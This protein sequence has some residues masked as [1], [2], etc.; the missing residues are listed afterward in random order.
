MI[1]LPENEIV[2]LESKHRFL[3]PKAHSGLP[4]SFLSEFPSLCTYNL[5]SGMSNISAFYAF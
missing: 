3:D 2:R 4:Q 5:Y 1:V